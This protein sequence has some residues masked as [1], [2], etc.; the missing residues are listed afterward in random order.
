MAEDTVTLPEVNVEDIFVGN[1]I[2]ISNL[3]EISGN[4]IRGISSDLVF[5]TTPGNSLDLTANDIYIN[6]F[7]SNLDNVIVQD[8]V[9][10][11]GSATIDDDNRGVEFLWDL[12]KIGFFG[13]NT[14]INR[15][16]FY[17][18]TT[19]SNPTSRSRWNKFSR[20]S[21][22]NNFVGFEVDKIYTSYITNADYD[23]EH[24]IGGVTNLQIKSTENINITTTKIRMDNYLEK[25]ENLNNKTVNSTNKTINTTIFS[26]TN[27]NATI[28]TNY[29]ISGTT[30]NTT[31]TSMT[32]ST[33]TSS[34]TQTTQGIEPINA[35]LIGFTNIYTDAFNS[36]SIDIE[37]NISSSSSV[38]FNDTVNNNNP[39]NMQKV[40]FN[41]QII[42]DMDDIT[43]INDV[44]I[45]TD[46]IKLDKT[47]KRIGF[48]TTP[49]YTLDVIGNVNFGA[50]ELNNNV[51]IG[52]NNTHSITINSSKITANNGLN[53]GNT[54][55]V[56]D[57]LGLNN[58]NPGV[59]FDITGTVNVD[60]FIKING[61]IDVDGSFNIST[62]NMTLNN[63]SVSDILNIDNTNNNVGINTTN[64]SGNI[65]SIG[66]S[67]LFNNNTVLS[68]DVILGLTTINSSTGTTN[69]MNIGDMVYYTKNNNNIGINKSDPEHKLHITTT[70]NKYIT[71]GSS[72]I[73]KSEYN[74]CVQT[75][76]TGT[77]NILSENIQN[78]MIMVRGEIMV[79][80]SMIQIEVSYKESTQI[81]QDIM[82]TNYD[83]NYVIGYNVI[84][85]IFNIVVNGKT[86]ETLNW[87]GRFDIYIIEI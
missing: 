57:K 80:T 28:N 55:Y 35:K 4:T 75:I 39:I 38:I 51:T 6:N 12:T 21:G 62:T 82:I 27:N 81:G 14:T 65:L 87:Y 8:D 26:A 43:L 52:Q 78:K 9:I 86:G 44:N 29:N 1:G 15:F 45:N 74:N 24:S 3:V 42:F 17:S 13:Y 16:V 60:D 20:I 67:A 84:T 47:N 73:S 77:A 31:T 76:N 54:L 72:Y 18:E 30:M 40:I 58:S 69:D 71:I 32:L 64:T 7:P 61:N 46:F 70:N 66:S 56:S 41:G 63:F 33:D 53:I 49:Q 59:G 10:T 2:T 36:G 25:E 83:D 23:N 48:N 11:L 68:Q 50:T 5:T 85:N 22:Y 37:S 19:Q 79:N 34:I